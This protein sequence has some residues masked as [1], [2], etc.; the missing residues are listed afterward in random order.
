MQKYCRETFKEHLEE[1]TANEM[2]RKPEECFLRYQKTNKYREFS[3]GPAVRTSCFHNRARV[4][5]LVWALRSHMTSSTIKKKKS[6]SNMRGL[7]HHLTN[8]CDLEENQNRKMNTGS[9]NTALI[10]R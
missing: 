1:G 10:V 7:V 6:I 4:S 8:L 9:G 2:V 3:G 5:T